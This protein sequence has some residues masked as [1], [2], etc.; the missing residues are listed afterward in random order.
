MLN[1]NIFPTCP[2]NIVNFGPLTA[3]IGSVVWH[4]P[5][6]F[7]GF[8]AL[9][10]LLQR[11]RSPEANQTLHDVWPSPWAGTLHIAGRPSRWALAHIS[12]TALVFVQINV[13]VVTNIVLRVQLP[14]QGSLIIIHRF[15]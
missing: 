13:I 3:E 8:H 7:N 6:N 12:S 9:A 11:R 10:S 1:S 2:H 4:T 14:Q 5:A 15:R